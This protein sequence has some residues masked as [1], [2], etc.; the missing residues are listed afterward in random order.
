MVR[1][2]IGGQTVD[3]MVDMGA[4]HSVV[5]QKVAPLLG[6][7]VTIIGATGDQ[8][9][10]PFCHP[11]R[12]QLGGHQVIHEF[13]YLPD[14]PVPLMGRDLLA[15][16]GAEITFAPDGSAQLRLGDL[17]N[18]PVLSSAKGGRME[19]LYPPDKGLTIRTELEK[20]FPLVWAEGNPPGLAKDHA[21]VLIEEARLGIQVHLDRLLQWGL[22]KRCRSPWNT[23]LLPVK[24]PG[25]NDYHPVQDLWAV[26]EAVITLHSALPNP[27][28]LLG[29]IPS[30]AEWFTCLHL[31]DAF[32]CLRLGPSS[33]PLF[34]FEWENPT[35]G[36]KEQFTWTRLPQ[37]FKNSLTLFSG[38]LASDLS[39]FPGQD[40][41]V[42]YSSYLV[43]KKKAQI[44]QK[45]V[46]YLGF[47]ITQGKRRLGTERKQAVCA[48][49]V[50]STRQQIRGFSDLAKPLYEALRGEEKAPI[51]WGPEQEK[52]LVTIKAK[53]TE[54]LALGLPGVTR[55][56]NLFVHENSGVALGVLTQEA[57]AATALLVKEADKLTLEQNLNVKVPHAAVTLMEAKRQHWLTHA[58]MTQYQG[59]LCENP[60]VRLEAVRTVNPATFLPITEG[61]SEHDCLEVLEEVYSSQ[62]DLIRAL[63]LS[64]N[65]R[66][67]IYTDL[68][69][70]FATLH[71][72][73]AI[74]KERGLLTAGGK[75][76]K[77][78][79]EILKL[80]ETVWE[81]K[82]ITIIHSKGHQKGKDSVS[83]GNQCADAATKLAAK[84]Q[85]SPAWIIL[86][87][88]LPEPPKYTPQEEKWAQKEGDKRTME[89]W[90]ILPGH[91]VYVPEQLAHKVVLQQHELSH[92]GKAALEALL[93]RYYLIAH[94]PSLCASVSQCCLLCAQNNAKQGWV[95][96]YPTHTEKVREVTK[97]LLKDIIPRYGM[98]LTI[99]SDNG[100][101]FVAEIVQQVAKALGIKRNLPTAYTPQ[102][103]AK[104]ERMNQTLKRAMA[105][106]CQ[107]TTLPRVRCTSRARVGFSPFEILYGRP[108]P[109]IQP[110]GDLGEIGKSRNN[111]KDLEKL[112]LRSTAVHPYKPRDQV[113]V[114]DWKREPLKPTWNGPYPV[115]LTTP[116]ALKVAGLNTWIHHSQVKAAHQ[117]SDIQSEWKVTS[118]QKHPLRITLKKTADLAKQPAPRNSD[119]TLLNSP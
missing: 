15:K 18:D 49:P 109:L 31:K 80:L 54:A 51:N 102:S 79:N 30:E 1:M 22:V 100:P 6:K 67:N 35:T 97:A 27:Y 50:P 81:P 83:E 37:G 96:A 19:T 60:R 65:K 85:A 34:A 43:S 17:P 84:E 68:P 3:F 8:T 106:L 95:E 117:P 101:A 89:G 77:N 110:K 76:I 75:G 86:A 55:D 91:R 62:P 58:Q 119:N 29:L 32:F 23:P 46:K 47:R 107:E 24:K 66:A 92:L 39:K 111:Y 13:L 87:P 16:M 64:K 7:E 59:L 88:E 38:A 26:N 118:D 4:E 70:A 41:G 12:C 112:S 21:P 63:E 42:F 90:C 11:H 82:E 52:A 116:T 9:R 61:A 103:S 45:E 57:L 73:G 48:I 10:R 72:H 25:T 14:C 28:T 78:L 114:K 105:K 33:Q 20:E 108:P 2:K 74:C 94:L 36:A 98:R 69:Y 5:T 56:F 115:I 93:G 104:V 44:C 113:W 53:L 99:G 40:L 71:V